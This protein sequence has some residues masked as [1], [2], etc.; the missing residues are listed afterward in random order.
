M[1]PYREANKAFS[2]AIEMGKGSLP[3]DFYGIEGS[4]TDHQRA[5]LE[6][7]LEITAACVQATYEDAAVKAAGIWEAEIN[8]LGRIAYGASWPW[9]KP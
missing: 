6:K 9:P 5:C 1:S 4:E 3:S 8:R 7:A 2:L